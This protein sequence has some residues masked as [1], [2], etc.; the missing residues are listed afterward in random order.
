MKFKKFKKLKNW[1]KRR[2]NSKL[3]IIGIILLPFLVELL[4]HT[5]LKNFLLVSQSDLLG[6]YGVALGVC[7]PIFQYFYQ[8]SEENRLRKKELKPIIAIS[9]EWNADNNYTLTLTKLSNNIIKDIFLYWEPLTNL[10]NEEQSFKI[11]FGSENNIDDVIYFSDTEYVNIDEDG[12]PKEI[13]LSCYDTENNL[14]QCEYK[15][16][17]RGDKPIYNICETCKI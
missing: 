16:F 6:Y 8:K 15:K 3:I 5:C 4:Y 1:C 14:W 12:Y 13:I 11:G 17:F 9:L 2:K 10:L 7:V